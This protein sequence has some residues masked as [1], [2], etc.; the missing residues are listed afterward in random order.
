MYRRTIGRLNMAATASVALVLSVAFSSYV[1]LSVVLIS[2]AM[3]GALAYDGPF[4]AS[5]S[6]AVPV[7]LAGGALP[8]A[9]GRLKPLPAGGH[10]R[11]DD[12]VQH[13]VSGTGVDCGRG[14]ACHDQVGKGGWKGALWN[15]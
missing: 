4:W 10:P 7:A 8:V 1:A 13:R 15:I 2:L 6:R 9:L 14:A 12:R 3:M 5:A 11:V